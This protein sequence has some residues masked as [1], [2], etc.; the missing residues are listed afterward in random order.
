MGE[1]I[2]TNNKKLKFLIFA[3]DVKYRIKDIEIITNG[4]KLIKSINNINL[5]SIKYLYEHIPAENE[6][7]Y[8]IKVYQS[9]GKIAIT[10]PI[11]IYHY[12]IIDE[13]TL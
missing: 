2:V 10:S 11:F 5:N 7:W 6:S 13:N 12:N 1:S 4:G 8:V 9:N 3:E